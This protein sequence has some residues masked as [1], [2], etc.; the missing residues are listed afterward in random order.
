MES[1]S[2]NKIKQ[3]NLDFNNMSIF[4]DI[5]YSDDDDFRMW[6]FGG[7]SMGSIFECE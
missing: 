5:F 6:T 3:E 1:K 7:V 4:L 2:V